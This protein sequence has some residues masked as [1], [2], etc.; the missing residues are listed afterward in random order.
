MQEFGTIKSAEAAWISNY[1]LSQNRIAI[2][3]SSLALYKYAIEL[4]LYRLDTCVSINSPPPDGHFIRH[5]AFSQR[6]YQD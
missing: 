2:F 1:Y 3:Q 6:E 4:M 5:P